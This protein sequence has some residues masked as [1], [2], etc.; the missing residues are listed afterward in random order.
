MGRPLF[1]IVIPAFNY[2]RFVGRAIDSALAQPGDDYELVVVD[3]G[4]TDDTPLVASSYG[5][6]IRYVRQERQ[7]V[8]LACKR[9]LNETHG[10]F[11]I[12]LDAD[13]ALAPDALTHLRREIDR[14]PDVGLIAGRHV[15]VTVTGRRFSGPI[16]FGKSRAANFRS[17]LLGRQVIC[18]GASAI[19][20]EAVDLLRRCY[21][22]NL[23]VGM[24]TACIAQTLWLYDAVAVDHVQLHV[25]EHPGRLR[26]NLAEIQLAGEA[27]VDAVFNAAIL[28]PEA[29]RYRAPFRSRLLRDR[30]RSY[31]KAGLDA[32]AVRHFHE[33]LRSDPGRTLGDLRNL[34]RY[35][36][37]RARQR[38]AAAPSFEID[39]LPSHEPGV[40]EVSGRKWLLG[41]RRHLSACAHEFLR[42]CSVLGDVVKLDLA[43]PTYLLSDP[44]DILHVFVNQPG[45]YSRTGLQVAF[46]QLF[47]QGLF[48]RTGRSHIDHRRVIQPLMHRGRLDGFLPPLRKTLA[49]FLPNW[50]NGQT[51]DASGTL[52]DVT[53]RAAGRMI[54]GLERA[55]DAAELFSAIHGSHQRV[56]KNMLSAVPLPEWLPTKRNRTLK[57]HIARL[58]AV[59]RR[60]IDEARARRPG[61]SLLSQLV[62]HRDGAGVPFTEGQIRDHALTIFLAAYEPPATGL[63]WILQ[64]LAV[65]PDV[66][67]RLQD[68]IDASERSIETE[69][70]ADAAGLLRQPY[71]SQVILEAMRLY[72]STWLLTRRAAEKDSLPSGASVPQG[73]DVFAS[74]LLVH[75]DARHYDQPEEF[76]PERFES[77]PTE[78]RAAG[79]YFPF[80]L[81]PTA[82]LGEYLARLMMAVTVQAILGRFSLEATSDDAPQIYS[83]NLFTMQPDRPIRLLLTAR[84]TA[85]HQTG[86]LAAA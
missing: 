76:R 31:H 72:P 86:V 50:H 24:E 56:V 15:N 82:C 30:A 78:R 58:D 47:G 80:G 48:S 29:V 18:T 65:H 41:H 2:G 13:D 40:V 26:D 12:F 6:R 23:R 11:L 44:R 4:S 39:R 9:G 79:I 59:M 36:I 17:F 14:R 73:A 8:F 10:Q 16:T 22:G 46:R 55:E 75:R 43:R 66:Q 33:A 69:G 84:S 85:A 63:T 19:R 20:R 60:L 68:E 64:L 61:N 7:G 67:R 49:E 5:S 1:S 37:S 25:Y 34:R 52:A 45:R 53:L 3:D 83:T 77:G 28:P 38:F 42:R 21:E 27:L 81:G 54:L 62:H 35:A 51:L 57:S 74:P 32:E 70:E 71:M